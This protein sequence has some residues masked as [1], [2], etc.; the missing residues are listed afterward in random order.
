[1]KAVIQCGEMGTSLRPFT[2]VLPQPLMPI[3]ARPVLELLLEVAAAA[4]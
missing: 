3:G 2:T 1:M 4:A